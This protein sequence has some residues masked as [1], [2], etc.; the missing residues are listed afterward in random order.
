MSTIATPATTLTL[1]DDESSLYLRLV[2][3]ELAL[4]LDASTYDEVLGQKIRQAMGMIGQYCSLCLQPTQVVATGITDGDMVPVG[5]VRG[6]VAITAPDTGATVTFTDLTNRQL[7][8]GP[9]PCFEARYS[10]DAAYTLTYTA[11]YSKN[12]EPKLPDG[13]VGAVVELSC[14]LF[15]KGGVSGGVLDNTW[16]TF[17]A[18]Y[19]RMGL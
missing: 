8:E 13:L 18:P 2:K 19:R 9:F 3:G 10:T 5:P 14:A 1:I 4:E 7:T 15:R 6:E 17:A 11:G 12:D 16:K